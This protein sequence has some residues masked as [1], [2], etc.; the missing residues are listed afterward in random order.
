MKLLAFDTSTDACTVAVMVDR[1]VHVDHR[2]A[3]RQHGT[4]LLPMID[5]L[6]AQAG[7]TAAQLDALI[8]GRGPGSFTGVRIG[9][10]TAQGIALGADIGVCGVS[11]LQSIAQGCHRQHADTSVA[12]SIDARMDEVYFCE[13]QCDQHELMMPLADEQIA[14]PDAVHREA[15][16]Y[17][18]GSGAERYEQ[19]LQEKYS[20]DITCIRRECLPQAV[21]LLTIGAGRIRQGQLEPA[22]LA[23][24]VY[25][26]NSVALTTAERAAKRALNQ[27]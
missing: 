17:W 26:R 13:Y 4:L 25:L 15:A 8:Y 18:A 19:I 11:T 6:M 22:E 27:Q 23:S 24:P 21:D 3:A 5:K 16:R 20:V 12:V 14:R 7:I 2:L 1:Q 10:A 9:V